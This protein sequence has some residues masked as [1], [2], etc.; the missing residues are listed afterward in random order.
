[1][2]SKF[3][4]FYPLEKEDFSSLWEEAVFA[5]DAN[6]LLNFYSYSHDTREELFNLLDTIADRLWLPNQAG[7]EYH[8][9]RPDRI[10]KEADRYEAITAPLEKILEDLKSGKSHPFI[11]SEMLSEYEELSEKISEALAQGKAAQQELVKEDPIRDR[12]TA[13]YQDKVGDPFSS[14]DLTNIFSEGARRYE[15]N[16]PPGYQ[17]HKKSEPDRY[18]DLVL[19]KQ[20]IDYARQNSRSVIFVT[21]DKKNDWW[22][23]ARNG[24]RIGPRPE[25]LKEFHEE[26]NQSVYIYSA[27]R[28]IEH[29][30]DKGTEISEKAV[31]EMAEV[32]ERRKSSLKQL[33]NALYSREL[34]DL[35][36]R[37]VQIDPD[38]FRKYTHAYEDG[39]RNIVTLPDSELRRIVERYE[40]SLG[41]LVDPADTELK[42]IVEKYENQIGDLKHPA[43]NEIMRLIERYEASH[44]DLEGPAQRA[45]GRLIADYEHSL[46]K[47]GS[48]HKADRTIENPQDEEENDGTER[49][50]DANP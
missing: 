45:L 14:D 41:N 16:I 39:I 11:G 43:E 27:D 47:F 26:A 46:R 50:G 7:Y 18:G 30:K 35:I 36:N 13:L 6:F 8:K 21:D 4:E 9:N 42:R 20:L 1:M 12:L 31:R 34:Q 19:W 17:D 2:K 23:I 24:E 44:R 3:S 33:R 32:S 49:G 37:Q 10:T 25:L 28:F 22:L 40:N 29:A 48:P 15:K 38:M 5:F